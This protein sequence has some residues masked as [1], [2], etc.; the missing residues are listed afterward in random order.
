MCDIGVLL[1]YHADSFKP[2][3]MEYQSLE[4][5]DVFDQQFWDPMVFIDALKGFDHDSPY[6]GVADEAVKQIGV[7]LW[8]VLGITIKHKVLICISP[9]ECNFRDAFETIATFKQMQ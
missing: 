1:Q 8:V 5:F 6:I 3:S 7:H 2:T 9:F 4:T